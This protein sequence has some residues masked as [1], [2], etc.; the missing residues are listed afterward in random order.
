MYSI[1]NKKSR[2]YSLFLQ[3]LF[4]IIALSLILALGFPLSKKLKKQYSV[5][6]EIKTLKEEIE[7]ENSKNSDL[8]KFIDYLNSDQ[9]IEEKARTNLN[10]RNE[11]EKVVVVKD[12]VT[13]NQNSLKDNFIYSS[14]NVDYIKNEKFENFKKWLNYFLN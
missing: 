12:E 13:Q 7:K 5:N 8:K 2:S 4:L 1:R 14:N 11:N 6:K 3:I 10:Y 9:Y